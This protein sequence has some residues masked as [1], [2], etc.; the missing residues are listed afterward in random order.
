MPVLACIVEGHGETTAFPVL[1]R[2]IACECGIFDLQIPKPI[3]SPKSKLLMAEHS[4]VVRHLDRVIRLAVN[5]LPGPTEGA[6]LVSLD[7]DTSC[8]KEVAAEIQRLVADI[9]S[10]IHCEVVLPTMEFE[11][12]FLAS[13][14]SLAEHRGVHDPVTVREPESVQGAKKLISEYLFPDDRNY[15][16][17]VDQQK[18]AAVMS[19]SQ[20]ARCRSFVHFLTTMGSMLAFLYPERQQQVEGAMDRLLEQGKQD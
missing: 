9:R 20:A 5:M 14:P 11:S 16:E 19:L 4:D 2:R 17:T 7:A 15:S 12:W 13:L 10:D 3:R 6:L 18:L 8:P 1:V